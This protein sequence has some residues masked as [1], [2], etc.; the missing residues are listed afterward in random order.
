MSD[1]QREILGL[2]AEG[3]IDVAEAERLLAALAAGEKR[4]EAGERAAG[5][6]QAGV[7]EALH[8]VRDTLAGIGPM[9]GRMAGEI[10]TEF[11]KDH[12]FPG[13]SEAGALPEIDEFEDGRF[14]VAAGERFYIRND[15]VD[16]PGGG[17][18]VIAGVPG[19]HCELE[20]GEARNLRV[21]RS[22]SGPVVRWSGGPLTVRVPETAA[23]VLA[24]T[25]GGDARVGGVSCPVQVKSMGGDLLLTDLGRRFQAKTMGGNIRIKLGAAGCEASEARTMGGNIRIDVGPAVPRTEAE[26]ATMGG[27]ILVEEAVG[28]VDKGS[29]LG[30]QKWTVHLG[31][32]EPAGSLRLRTMG[33]NI[34]I[35]RARDDH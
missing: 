8:S 22:S 3:R 11:Q 32:G 23:E 21:L 2:L 17:D 19:E 13:E 14:A 25:L 35:R 29:S 12:T 27:S 34:E 10:A 33:G 20:A 5:R 9:M 4:R 15:K 7:Q 28:E 31:G 30:K 16:G 24:Y 26:A 1:E 6:R 18:L